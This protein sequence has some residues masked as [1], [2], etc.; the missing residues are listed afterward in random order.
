MQTMDRSRWE[1]VSPVL[2]ELLD[3]DPAPRAERLSALRAEDP[4]LGAE[5][6][7]MLQRLDVLEHDSFL[8]SPARLPDPG[9]AGQTVGAYTIVREL[10]R[11]GMGSVWLAQR[12]D[13]RY[14]GNVAVKFLTG[15]AL[16]RGSAERFAREG[17]ILARLAHPHIARLIDA[18]VSADGQRYLVLEYIDGETIDRY[19]ERMALDVTARVR[20]FIDVLAAVAHAHNRLIL[21]RDIKP[22]NIL[23]TQA[24][25]VKL[26]DFGVAKLMDDATVP[27]AATEL[28]Q[29]AGRAYTPAY[30]APEQVEDGDVT[31]ATDVYALGVLL[32]GLLGGGHPTAVPGCTTLEQLRAVVEAEPRRLSEAVGRK[33][34]GDVAT[35]KRARELRG[36][37]DNVVAKALK[38]VPAERYANAQHMADDLWRYLRHEPVSARPD[39][40]GYVLA[41]FVRRH[42]AG[43][44]ASALMATA[45]AMGI[46]VALWEASE[47][48]HQRVQA[49]S[50]IEFMLG[51]L[52]KKLQ[53][54]GRL[55][56]LGAVGEK[57]LRY[58]AA[59]DAG[60]LDADSL[61][62]K[63]RALHLI[64][65]IADRRG[66]LDEAQQ[67][68][69]QAG[70]S[71]A[72]LL[73]RAPQD[74][75][76]LFDHAQSQ[77]WVG[78]A[79]VRRGDL[80]AAR[81]AFDQYLQL[82]Q[83]LRG[84][85]PERLEW[86]EEEAHAY[87]NLGILHLQMAQVGEALAALNAARQTWVRLAAI[88]PALQWEHANVV[89]WIA[90]ASEAQ[91]DY[92]AAL[93]GQQAKLDILRAAPDA[94]SR[95]VQGLE[96]N[97]H[98]QLARLYLTL[99]QPTRAAE[100]A[101]EAQK[102]YAAL[103]ALDGNNADWRAQLALSHAMW[104]Q[105]L[106]AQGQAAAALGQRGLALA[107]SP[108]WTDSAERRK[109][110][111]Y[112][113]LAG[114]LTILQAQW[115]AGSA[116]TAADQALQEFVQQ[117]GSGTLAGAG[118]RA[119]HEMTVAEAELL[120][121]DRLLP[122]DA[123]AAVRYWQAAAV[124]LAA[125]SGGREADPARLALL[126]HAR[127]RLGADAEA[128]ALAVRIDSTL[129]RH[130]VY[131]DLRKRLALP[132]G[133]E[134][135]STIP[136]NNP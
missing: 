113:S 8:Q 59:Q 21:H 32:Y 15:G 115:Q 93:Q 28:T 74:A 103:V 71:T 20:L 136:R 12:A 130:P 38:K 78:Q 96:A 92:R 25:E 6:S 90:K 56:A 9:M 111:W 101:Q 2:D 79:A 65:E 57:V 51:D 94:A 73:A 75:S 54:V 27:A 50:L 26:L 18:G 125:S 89:G 82:A 49:E 127:L 24:G 131:A 67:V 36:D 10:G 68:F 91:G 112:L 5:L 64:G 77:F 33:G 35:A 60:R 29:L 109:N 69:Q 132:A 17:S 66:R 1:R 87:G 72:E 58:Y 98:Y 86:Q 121:G 63:A 31:T 52:R 99:G 133:G 84:Q 34:G 88:R 3:L 7:D 22:G 13:G 107:V 102:Q 47:A 55:D 48:R 97:G 135:G 105:S 70:D 42:R 4:G 41:K 117:A 37:L 134:A 80:D 43:V 106:W 46:G 85:E 44:A 83:R 16:L 100:A 39:A 124:R 14:E 129:Y 128:R 123:A 19:C 110:K 108:P 116:W 122:R 40:P 104:A 126:A 118:V 81:A 61:G 45:L 120:L 23:V 53:P 95:R 76:R 119:E 11:G 30:A 114:P 62:R